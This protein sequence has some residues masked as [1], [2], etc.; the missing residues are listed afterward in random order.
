MKCDFVY[1]TSKLHVCQ[2]PEQKNKHSMNNKKVANPDTRQD[3]L[4]HLEEQYQGVFST[5]VLNSHLED[6]IGTTFTDQVAPVVAAHVPAGS[7]ILDIGSGYGSFVIAAHRLGFRPFGLEPAQF[8]VH[9]SQNRLEQDAPELIGRSPFLYGDG[10]NLPYLNNSFNAV[11]LWNVLEHI[12]NLDDVLNEVDR[13]LKPGGHVF[14]ICPNYAAFRME[15]HYLIFWFPLLPRGLAILYLKLRGK[16]PDFFKNSIF[17]RT[18]WEVLASLK[19]RRFQAR[20]LDGSP[21]KPNQV[22]LSS[23][24]LE[25]IKKPEIISSPFLRLIF[26]TI[27]ILHLQRMAIIMIRAIQRCRS[28][29]DWFLFLKSMFS[30]YNPFIESIVL[31]A[32]KN[33]TA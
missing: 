1:R 18:N 29:P 30:L 5:Q 33:H 32:R 10:K 15:A 23:V 17:Y 21:Q 24:I 4:A 8:D 31:S 11:A 12:D 19:K 6:Y 3:L 16:N 14:I 27:K 20:R 9:Y 26:K 7:Q 2:Y 22:Y 25:K 13:V 28:I